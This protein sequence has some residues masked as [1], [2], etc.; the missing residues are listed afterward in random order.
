MSFDPNAHII[1][2]RGKGGTADYLPVA[3]R[4]AWFRDKHPDGH[5]AV[6]AHTISE[7]I[8][9]FHARVS[10]PEGGSAEGWGS[11][12]PRDFGDYIEK[13]STKA[14]GRALLA[15]GFG[16]MQAGEELDEGA[17]IADAPVARP[18]QARPAPNANTGRAQVAPADPDDLN[19]NPPGSAEHVLFEARRLAQAGHTVPEVWSFL[20]SR[21]AALG[22]DW[23]AVLGEWKHIK[24]SIEARRQPPAGVA[25]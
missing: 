23:Q 1:Q 8:A 7:Q 4:I 15:L 24:A 19:P 22:G 16:T 9:I 17:R 3:A 6:A 12:T 13:A 14:L 20:T 10:I 21:Q 25:G 5:I 11:E 2:L 18:Q